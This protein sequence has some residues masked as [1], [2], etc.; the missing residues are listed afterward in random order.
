MQALKSSIIFCVLLM[1]LGEIGAT[2]NVKNHR[3]KHFDYKT[4]TFFWRNTH[5]TVLTAMLSDANMRMEK[6][7]KPLPEYIEPSLENIK[8]Q[9]EAIYITNARNTVIPQYYIE[10]FNTTSLRI[11]NSDYSKVTPFTSRCS[12]L[13]NLYLGENEINSIDHHAFDQLSN[14]VTLYLNDNQLTSLSDKLFHHLE[15]LELIML[16]NNKLSSINEH[17]FANNV[18]L[19]YIY[20]DNNELSVIS[21]HLFTPNLRAIDLRENNCIDM[22]TGY[23]NLTQIKCFLESNCTAV[24]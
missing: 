24:N 20:L 6:F 19:G 16:S 22:K 3:R 23:Y 1:A 21:P 9:V 4:M 12:R 5:D 14:V 2:N 8:D 15:N 11:D 7:M 17:L 18:N 13:L 10:Y